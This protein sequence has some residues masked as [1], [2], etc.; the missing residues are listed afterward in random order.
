LGSGMFIPGFE[1][2]LVGAAIG[3][4]VDVNVTFPEQ[5]HAPDLAGKEAVFRCKIHEIHAKEM[6]PMDDTF[7]QGVAGLATLEEMKA[8]L[9]K[10][11]EEYAENMAQSQVNDRLLEALVA[12]TQDVEIT[13][14]MMA[15]ELESAVARISQ[16]MAQQGIPMEAYLQFYGKTMDEFR[17]D[18]RPQAENSLKARLALEEV[19]RLE[20]VTVSDEELEVEVQLMAR[21][22]GISVEQL[23][24]LMGEGVAL[25]NLRKDTVVKKTVKVLLDN[26]VITVEQA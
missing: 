6:Y 18:L 12:E 13:E 19:S 15:A 5:Y 11:M 4:D 16:Q 9:K 21:E 20:N 1:E 23:K 10:N 24:T 3:A 7:A 2:Q 22:F 17:Q 8:V 14:A 26:A 25:E